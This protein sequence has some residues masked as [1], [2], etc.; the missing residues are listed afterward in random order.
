M[1]KYCE[2][3]ARKQ[4]GEVAWG[5]ILA[6]T[7]NSRSYFPISWYSVR[8][9]RRAAKFD[10]CGSGRWKQSDHWPWLVKK[11]IG[12]LDRY[13]CFN[14][15]WSFNLVAFTASTGYTY[16]V[17]GYV[18]ASGLTAVILSTRQ[19]KISND[20][21]HL[22]SV[23]DWSFSLISVEPGGNTLNLFYISLHHPC[24]VSTEIDGKLIWCLRGDDVRVATESLV[25]SR[26]NL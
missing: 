14:F 12:W 5:Y 2:V 13:R 15:A 20:F 19:R 16:A 7:N 22:S 23:W 21:E 17:A 9:M 10:V 26:E 25:S 3:Q 11:K 24:V 4:D 18:H 6:Y 8:V 1:C